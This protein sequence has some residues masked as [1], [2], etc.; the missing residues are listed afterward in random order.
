MTGE[1]LARIRTCQACR[2]WRAACADYWN[3]PRCIHG[4][5]ERDLSDEFLEGPESNCPITAWTG[6][7]PLD[8]E[9]VAAEERMI[10]YEHDRR[11]VRSLL[12]HVFED[13]IAHVDVAK[14]R[15]WITNMISRGECPLWLAVEI[16]ALLESAGLPA[17]AHLTV[18]QDGAAAILAGGGNDAAWCSLRDCVEAE[19]CTAAEAQAVADSLGITEP[20]A[21]GA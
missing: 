3:W 11:M 7:E 4:G 13:A 21:G 6:L 12:R 20:S 1:K 15:A 14:L 8:L 5:V 10:G 2:H 18:L 17:G 16:T 19:A 9:E